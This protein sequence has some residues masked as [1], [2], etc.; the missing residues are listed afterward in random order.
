LRLPGDSGI[1]LPGHWF[2][3]AVSAGGVP[4][5]AKTVLVQL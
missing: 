3:F 1:V 5:V 2:L 4:S